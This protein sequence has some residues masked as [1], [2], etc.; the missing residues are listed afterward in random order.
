MTSPSSRDQLHLEQVERGKENGSGKTHGATATV[1]SRACQSE[2]QQ[3]RWL[4]YEE[5]QGHRSKAGLPYARDL[6]RAAACPRAQIAAVLSSHAHGHRQFLIAGRGLKQR[7]RELLLL[8]PGD[9]HA[10]IALAALVAV[11]FKGEEG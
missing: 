4:L 10:V 7:I 6:G 5:G 2:S 9:L 1:A 11:H 3:Q 8:D